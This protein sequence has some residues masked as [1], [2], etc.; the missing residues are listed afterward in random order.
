MG[1][2]D[3]KVKQQMADIAP[4]ILKIDQLISLSRLNELA[5]IMNTDRTDRLARIIAATDQLKPGAYLLGTGPATTGIIP[6]T[7]EE[8]VIGRAATPLEKPSDG[9]AD[10]TVADTLYFGPRETSR[11]HARIVRRWTESVPIYVLMD[12][13]STC[14]TFVN[15]HRL[16]GASGHTLVHGDV[17]SLGASQVSTYVFFLKEEQPQQGGV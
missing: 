5:A 12:M 8:V 10:Y 14:G 4:I 17:I 2:L 3:R 9:I 15:G 1:R 13:G 7:V 11:L 6:L 16:E